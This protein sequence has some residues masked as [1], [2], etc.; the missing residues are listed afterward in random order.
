MAVIWTSF[1]AELRVEL[2]DPVP[3]T[4]SPR[5]S[6]DLLYLYTRDGIRDYSQYFPLSVHQQLLHRS[7]WYAALMFF[8]GCDGC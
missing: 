8:P 1:L 5:Y 6:D 4:G 7:G 2:T 3:Q